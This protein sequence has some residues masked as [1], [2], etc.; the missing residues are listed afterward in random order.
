MATLRS[1]KKLFSHFD[2]LHHY[3]RSIERRLW[4]YRLIPVVAIVAGSVSIAASFGGPIAAFAVL[5]VTLLASRAVADAFLTQISDG[6]AEL[7]RALDHTETEKTQIRQKT[8][9]LIAQFPTRRKA[10]QFKVAYSLKNKPVA[11]LEAA[12]ALGMYKEGKEVMEK[13][14]SHLVLSEFSP[15]IGY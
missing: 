7:C 10:E 11:D 1:N 9:D 15:G 3:S 13:K 12:L 2:N 8:T 5:L 6:F 14:E 4:H